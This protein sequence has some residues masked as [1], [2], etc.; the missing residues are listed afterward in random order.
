MIR[1]LMVLL[2]SHASAQASPAERAVFAP[3]PA[4][5]GANQIVKDPSLIV[6]GGEDAWRALVCDGRGS[7]CDPGGIV[8]R[9]G[10]GPATREF[11]EPS[12]IATLAGA[13]V[14]RIVVKQYRENGWTGPHR[15]WLDIEQEIRRVWSASV[16]Q[17]WGQIVWAEGSR[18]NVFAVIEFEDSPRRGS[19]LTDGFHVQVQ[20]VNGQYWFTRLRV[21][22]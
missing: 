20:D 9:Q 7:T 1:F 6:G 21:D 15:D 13:K 16:Q 12:T 2:L 11:S 14:S 8:P 22:Q 3:Q 19:L 17:A 10:G 4:I 5:L 18:W